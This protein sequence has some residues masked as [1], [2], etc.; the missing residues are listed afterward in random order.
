MT[1][2]KSSINFISWNVNGLRACRNKTFD[3]F[4]EDVSPDFLCLQEVKLNQDVI[5]QEDFGY[6]FRHYHLAEK[7]GYS[8]TAIFSKTEP[9]SVSEDF[10]DGKHGGEG[11]VITCEYDGFF[12]VNVYVPNSKGDL[13]R[14]PYRYQCW[15]P[16]LKDYV[17]E[18]RAKKPVVLCGDLNV[19]H[20][21]IDLANPKTNRKSAGF[22]DQEREGISNLL[23]EGFLDTFRHL[24][25]DQEHAYSWWSYRAGAR[26]R[27]VGWR[28]DYF[29]VS[30]DLATSVRDATILAKVE[31]SDH[32]PVGLTLTQA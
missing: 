15:D 9:L 28:I 21:E 32:C 27:N 16:D 14:L 6:A 22:T 31:G 10:P 13:S 7:K 12:L 23:A 26:A 18:L 2:Q 4:I 19:A 29:V 30:D 20:R 25:P 11:R 1:N 24:H 17:I 3:N 8:G 5:P